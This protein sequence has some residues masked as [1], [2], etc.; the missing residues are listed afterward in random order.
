MGTNK[1]K[2]F[3]HQTRVKAPVEAVAEFH[4]DSQALKRLTPPPV[5][6][7]IHSM[8]PLAENSM[9]DFTMWMGPLP[10]RWVAIHTDVDPKRGFKDSQLRGPFARWEHRHTF[11]ALDD[12]NSVVIDEIEAEY[13]RGFWGLLGRLMWLNLSFMF[14]YRGWV[15]RRSV[16]RTQFVNRPVSG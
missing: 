4:H 10:V 8:E 11:V 3:R 12:K 9:T 5:F 13:G 7:Q 14:A 16:E 1:I 6:V 15:T 2:K